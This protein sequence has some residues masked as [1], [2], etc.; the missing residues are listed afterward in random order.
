[1]NFLYCPPRNIA[2]EEVHKRYAQVEH[3]KRRGKTAASIGIGERRE[4]QLKDS[5]G[6]NRLISG[7]EHDEI[8][9]IIVE[10]PFERHLAISF[11]GK[12]GSAH[13]I[14][15]DQNE[16]IDTSLTPHSECSQERVF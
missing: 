9:H 4:D 13:K 7:I 14:A 6:R 3:Q 8:N 1:M 10:D 12:S 2:D 15:A 11:D 16:N 5:Q